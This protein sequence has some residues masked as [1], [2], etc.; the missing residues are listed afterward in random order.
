M[1]NGRQPSRSDLLS[2]LTEACELEHG[3]ICSYLFTAFTLKNDVSEGGLTERQLQ[4][5]RGWAESLYSVAVQEMFHLAQ[6]WNLLAA[7]GGT[8]YYLRPNFPQGT[9]Y[10]PM[11]ADLK[12]E[13]FGQRAV[14]RFIFYER[15]RIVDREA[16]GVAIEPGVTPGQAR[17]RT[18][19]GLYDLIQ[20]TY[21]AIP[22]EQLFVS[23]ESSQVTAQQVYLRDLVTVVDR[24]SARAAITKITEQGEGAEAGWATSHHGIFTSIKEAYEREVRAARRRGE[25]YEPARPSVTNPVARLRGDYGAGRVTLLVDDYAKRVSELFDETYNLMLRMLQYV[26]R[27]PRADPKILDWFVRT[28]VGLMPMVIKPL[29]EALTALPSGLESGGTAGPSFAMTRHV[30]LASDAQVASILAWERLVELV[31][32]AREAADAPVAPVGVGKA[33]DSLAKLLPRRAAA[34][35]S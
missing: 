21:D 18:V 8:P 7:I 29:G 30:P 28:S 6:A 19:G 17:Y 26:F 4:R 13:P 15:P 16:G 32:M 3:L 27:N 23:A 24:A 33:A 1:Q 9:K 5:V 10:Y 11:E 25:T 31:D 22:E 20:Q 35:T 34:L 14:E 12:L 2:L